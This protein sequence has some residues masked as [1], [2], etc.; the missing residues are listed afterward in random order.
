MCY[1]FSLLTLFLGIYFGWFFGKRSEERI[2]NVILN[3]LNRKSNQLRSDIESEKKENY[4]KKDYPEITEEKR[5]KQIFLTVSVTKKIKKEGKNTQIAVERA[6]RRLA[7]GIH[8]PSIK[9]LL[10]SRFY[11][12]RIGKYRLIFE[13]KEDKILVVD[14]IKR[15]HLPKAL[16]E[17]S[18]LNI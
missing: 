5:R 4:I 7:E 2:I 6:L 10:K 8:F 9:K 18:I 15:S 3:R 11:V 16:K 1:L 13:D 14:F 12:Y 17:I